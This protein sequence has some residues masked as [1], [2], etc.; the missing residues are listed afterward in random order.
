MK[1]TSKDLLK[2]LVDHEKRISRLESS[3][4]KIKPPRVKKNIS[5]PDHILALRDKGFFAKPKTVEDTQNRLSD[6]YSC[7]KNRVAVALLRL[8]TKKQLRRTST[9]KNDKNNIAFT[10]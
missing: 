4:A 5:L 3:G 6:F 7:D 9:K 10:W 8:S 1:N 2:V